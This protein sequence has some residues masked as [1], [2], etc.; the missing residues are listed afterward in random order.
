[1]VNHSGE[2]IILVNHS[3]EPSSSPSSSSDL[4]TLGLGMGLDPPDRGP[5]DGLDPPDRD[6]SSLRIGLLRYSSSSSSS[7]LLRFF[8]SCFF[9]SFFFVGDKPRYE[10]YQQSNGQWAMGTWGSL[11]KMGRTALE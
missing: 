5:P 7:S 10:V 3:G 2:S 4:D 8:L 11:V 1:M 6:G 9:L